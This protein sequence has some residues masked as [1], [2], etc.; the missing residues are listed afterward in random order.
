MTLNR[1]NQRGK[2]WYKRNKSSNTTIQVNRNITIINCIIYV[3]EFFSHWQ[4]T[5]KKY[6]SRFSWNSWDVLF[7]FQI[8]VTVLR[9]L[10]QYPKFNIKFLHQT[11]FTSIILFD[12]TFILWINPICVFILSVSY[13]FNFECEFPDY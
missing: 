3:L 4:N 9:E 6:F 12:R 2:I 1:P 11:F 10:F 5:R 7:Y 8:L 13:Q